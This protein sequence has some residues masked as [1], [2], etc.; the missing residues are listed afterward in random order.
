MKIKNAGFEDAKSIAKVHVDSW[1]TTYK[2]IVPNEYL[3]TLSYETRENL[4]EQAI[5]RGHV[6]AAEN[7]NGQ[8]VGFACGGKERTGNYPEYEGEIYAIY[9]LKEFQKQGIG[10]EL[11]RA[12]VQH[13]QGN[14]LN[15]MLIWVL[16]DNESSFF[17]EALG[18]VKIDSMEC[19]IGGRKLKETAYGWKDLSLINK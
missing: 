4:W 2:D 5:P 19:E 6:F 3:Q 13:L 12:V 15:S 10:T 11:I 14:R 18:G 9:L 7:E 1:R 16:E 17:Y 8:V